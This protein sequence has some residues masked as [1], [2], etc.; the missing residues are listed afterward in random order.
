M[1]LSV[2]EPK[3]KEQLMEWHSEDQ[4]SNFSD[5]KNTLS[6]Y[7]RG[8]RK[9]LSNLEKANK[10]ENFMEFLAEFNIA[11]LFILKKIDFDYEKKS[12]EDF[13]LSQGGFEISVKSLMRKKYQLEEE[14][15]IF[16][17][18]EEALKDNCRKSV[19]INY[20]H[21]D[22][23]IVVQPMDM[24]KGT[25]STQRTEI[26]KAGAVLSSEMQQK[27]AIIK[28]INKFDKKKSDKRK[29]LLFTT[30]NS[31]CPIV[32]FNEIIHH[33]Y[34][35]KPLNGHDALPYD[36]YFEK[37]LNRDIVGFIVIYLPNEILCWKESSLLDK[38]TNNDGSVSFRFNFFGT[39]SVHEEIT[40]VF[41]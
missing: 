18:R 36:K 25:V 30:Q 41:F 39:K 22:V 6:K 8:C 1:Y 7:Q 23:S 27:S 33:Y 16:K 32:L 10:L 5:W 12:Y 3:T 17:L 34:N 4:R 11:R 14:G 31:D 28:Y 21:S 37:N 9:L 40:K 19:T 20:S 35:G 38:E 13:L 24:S 2:L 15:L 29:I 26:G